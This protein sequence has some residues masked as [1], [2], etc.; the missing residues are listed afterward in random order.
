MLKV[1]NVKILKLKCGILPTVKSPTVN[2]A[3]CQHCELSTV[4]TDR[5]STMPTETA[6]NCQLS[7]LLTVTSNVSIAFHYN[8]CLP[9]LIQVILRL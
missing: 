9:M 2:T 8:G 4:K 6:T 7:K 1:Y 5:L 3:N